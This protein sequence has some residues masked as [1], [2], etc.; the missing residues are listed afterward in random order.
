MDRV[1]G[2]ITLWREEGTYGVVGLNEG[3]VDSDDLSL[4]VLDAVPM[5]E[6]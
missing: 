6:C 3:V 5:L 1:S 2:T 4:A